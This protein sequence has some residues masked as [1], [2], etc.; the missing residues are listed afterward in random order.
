MKVSWRSEN[1]FT[2]HIYIIDLTEAFIKAENNPS[3]AENNSSAAENEPAK[4]E[5]NQRTQLLKELIMIESIQT[6]Y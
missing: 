2:F 4:V 5:T 1:T 6:V 3:V